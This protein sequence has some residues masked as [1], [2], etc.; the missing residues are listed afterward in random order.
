MPRVTSET[1]AFTSAAP[2]VASLAI[3]CCHTNTQ[4]HAKGVCRLG[5]W[6]L[7]ATRLLS[8]TIPSAGVS[9]GP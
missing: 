4:L 6:A 2:L 9:H 7:L 5:G 3:A 8:A 1:H